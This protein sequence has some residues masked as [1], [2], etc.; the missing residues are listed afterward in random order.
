MGKSKTYGK[1]PKVEVTD[2]PEVIRYDYCFN[3]LK[4]KDGVRI[5]VGNT[6]A[7]PE[8]FQTI[9]EAQKY[10]DSKPWGLIV[11]VTHICH[12]IINEQQNNK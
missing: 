9:E 1:V 6:V 4:N 12:K 10:V 2:V 8:V 3:L 7:T 5:A 11:A